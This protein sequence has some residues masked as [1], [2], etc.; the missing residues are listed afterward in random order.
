MSNRKISFLSIFD[1]L[2]VLSPK[3]RINRFVIIRNSTIGDYTFIGPNSSIL[4][5]SIG[6][7]C[8]ISKNVNIG[9][10]LHPTNFFST[11]PIF[12]REHNGNGYSWVKGQ[13]FD[14]RS[15]DINIGND[16]WIGLNVTIMG[17]IKI[18]DGAIIAAHS[19]V[20]KDIPPYAIYGGVPARLIK[21]RFDSE[22]IDSLL[23]LKWWDFPTEILEK[24]A[25]L[26]AN[27][28]DLNT[29]ERIRSLNYDKINCN[30]S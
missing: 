18:G 5:T 27:Q 14:D 28:V 25:S 6:K 8:S 1:H 12:F 17:G 7:F 13:L 10:P 21:Y 22:I 24:Y 20:T 16:I 30:L 19:V 11:S 23:N 26:F 4:N 2:S 9:A 29:I 3:S 15:K